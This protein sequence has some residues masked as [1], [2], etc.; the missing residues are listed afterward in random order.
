MCTFNKEQNRQTTA[1]LPFTLSTNTDIFDC[2]ILIWIHY[3][4]FFP[5]CAHNSLITTLQIPSCECK[6]CDPCNTVP[7][8][9]CP[10]SHGKR[11]G[12]YVCMNG[13]MSAN[14]VKRYI[15][16]KK[17]L[18]KWAPSRVNFRSVLWPSPA[19]QWE[20]LMWST[21]GFLQYVRRAAVVNAKWSWSDVCCWT[22]LTQLGVNVY[23]WLI[24]ST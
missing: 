20:G 14:T 22:I 19:G 23:R 15:N 17:A 8:T 9:Y 21:L 4:L 5:K 10:F 7:G 1:N 18:Y 13:W 11:R 12:I 16:K 2:A 24:H 3:N 6:I